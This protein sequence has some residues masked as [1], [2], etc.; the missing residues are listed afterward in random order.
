MTSPPSSEPFCSPTTLSLMLIV[1]LRALLK[2]C[3]CVELDCW[4]GS[5]D[6]PVI[7][8][9]YTLTSKIL[10]KDA[11]KAIKEYAFK[12]CLVRFRFIKYPRTLYIFYSLF[13]HSSPD[14]RLPSHP[15]LG[16]P[17]LCGA[18]GSHGPP[19]EL[20]PGQCTHHFPPGGRH[21]HKFP[22][23]RGFYPLLSLVDYVF[24]TDCCKDAS[25]SI[26]LYCLCISRS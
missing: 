22:I 20:Y 18:A 2:G 3:R 9:G 15:L 7:Y 11:I 12:V 5:D 1:S 6:E 4:D 23:S 26:T 24:M 21:A 16:E 19:H 10:F 17:L 25:H 8:H 13:S 14:I